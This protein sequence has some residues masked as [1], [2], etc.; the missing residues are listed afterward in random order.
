AGWPREPGPEP[1]GSGRRARRGDRDGRD[2][3]P[4]HVRPGGGAGAGRRAGCRGARLLGLGPAVR[5]HGGGERRRGP[6]RAAGRAAAGLAQR[7][8]DAVL[9]GDKTATSSALWD[10]EDEG[11]PLPVVG[12]L[13]IL[14][15]GEGHP[16][17]LIRTTSVETVAFEDVDE[18]FAA[19]EG[20][21]DRTLASWRAAHETFFRP[22]LGEGR[23]FAPDMPLV[24]ERF[25]LL[26][27][28]R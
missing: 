23:E 6:A 15:D 27:P 1:A 26:Y 24:C 7:L 11:A 13:S 9:A 16:R 3:R 28:K 22:R 25:E 19:A 18:E 20:E 17:A 21:D 12:E 4:R 2:L 5:G 14:L 8:L 10:Y